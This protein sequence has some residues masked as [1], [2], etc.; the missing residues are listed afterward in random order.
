MCFVLG[1]HQ[2]STKSARELQLGILVS[3]GDP[4]RSYLNLSLVFAS[5]PGRSLNTQKIFFS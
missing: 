3:K 1:A 4:P 2:V 5:K